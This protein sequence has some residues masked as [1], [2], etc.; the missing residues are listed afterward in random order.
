[1]PTRRTTRVTRPPVGAGRGAS[2][3]G[4][5]LGAGRRRG[6]GAPRGGRGGSAARA[7]GA[8]RGGGRLRP[9]QRRNAPPGPLPETIDWVVKPSAAQ[10]QALLRE[11]GAIF[12]TEESESWPI[13]GHKIFICRGGTWVKDAAFSGKSKHTLDVWRNFSQTLHGELLRLYGAGLGFGGGDAPEAP[14]ED[15]DEKEDDDVEN[16]GNEVEEEDEDFDVD[17]GAGYQADGT[18]YGPND[19]VPP[20]G[21]RGRKKGTKRQFTTLAS[22]DP[23]APPN[24]Q[25]SGAKSTPS[26]V[27][28]PRDPDPEDIWKQ[29]GVVENASAEQGLPRQV[30]T[31][32]F[33]VIIF[34]VV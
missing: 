13:R 22:E 28:I 19:P 33:G 34:V 21:N 20:S 14:A 6:G 27:R 15:T 7:R 1:M 25:P 5:S 31:F 10:Q 17:Q 3:G 12:P 24:K 2:R 4:G 26:Q 9:P 16:D 11:I 30:A 23:S 18:K 8:G 32:I 29:L